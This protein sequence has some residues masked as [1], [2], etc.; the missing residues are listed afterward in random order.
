MK[1]HD[2]IS[3][4][5]ITCQDK[6]YIY[7][8]DFCFNVLFI[9]FM[10]MSEQIFSNSMQTQLTVGL[11]FHVL[12][13]LSLIFYCSFYTAKWMLLMFFE[14]AEYQHDTYYYYY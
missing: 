5:D 7:G 14:E 8:N 12:K 10:P 13:T 2:M 6:H 9:Q 4:H 1:L 3:L 11:S